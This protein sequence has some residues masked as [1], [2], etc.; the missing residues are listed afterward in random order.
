MRP[1]RAAK[2]LQAVANNTAAVTP[3]CPKTGVAGPKIDVTT[4]KTISAASETTLDAPN[5]APVA[6][7]NLKACPKKNGKKKFGQKAG[8]PRAAEKGDNGGGEDEEDHEDYGGPP[9]A[10]N[11]AVSATSACSNTASTLKLTEVSKVAGGAYGS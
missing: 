10:G 7:I 3:K 1:S 4:P 11:V 8:V 2:L 9:S 5:A 6:D